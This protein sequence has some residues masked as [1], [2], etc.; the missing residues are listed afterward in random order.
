MRQFLS[1]AG[2]PLALSSPPACNLKNVRRDEGLQSGKIFVLHGLI[3]GAALGKQ[4]SLQGGVCEVLR[5]C[6][7]G[8]QRQ[9]NAESFHARNAM[10]R[11]DPALQLLQRVLRSLVA[12]GAAGRPPARH[13]RMPLVW[14]SS[15]S[16][17][18][19]R[20]SSSMVG[21][22]AMAATAASMVLVRQGSVVT[23]KGSASLG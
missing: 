22:L 13:D 21:I 3:G 6:G 18:R 20:G 5:G 14:S 7:A 12:E 16:I 4:R 8:Q 19:Q 17:C 15:T 9:Q 2:K 1:M 11:R 23:T 10:T